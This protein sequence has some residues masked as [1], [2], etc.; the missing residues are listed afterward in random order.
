MKP[1]VKRQIVAIDESKC[2]G[3]GRCVV[4]CVEGALQIVDG[5]A[6]LVKE[7]LCDGLAA[8]VGECPRG[9][10]TIVERLA[11]PFEMP[12][13]ARPA[14]PVAAREGAAPSALQNWPVQLRLVPPA[15][16]YLQG[17][18]LLISADC[19]PFAFGGFHQELL[20]GKLVLVG[21]PKL[22]DAASYRD[23]LA[24]I[25]AA[26]DIASVEVVHMEVPC[27]RALA[28]IVREALQ[29]AGKE[30]PS[31]RT[32]ISV[33]GEVV[34]QDDL[35]GPERPDVHSAGPACPHHV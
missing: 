4:G 19:V 10:I 11:D 32:V 3:C 23:K 31:A 2:D 21:C 27:C 25:F 33:G 30:L 17:A 7:S 1:K 5:K 8:C 6:R 13:A 24:A 34:A 35:S 26:N 18:H 12:E 22:D 15:A 9:A 29:E 16:P 14:P 28:R 20:P